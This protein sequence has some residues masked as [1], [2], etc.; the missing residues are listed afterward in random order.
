[1]TPLFD[2]A[3]VH[4]AAHRW[5]SIGRTT[6]LLFGLLVV[7]SPAAAQDAAASRPEMQRSG[8]R[9]LSG[10][11]TFGVE[12]P[13][14][15]IPADHTFRAVF[16]IV[17]GDGGGDQPHQEI[18]T[19]ARFMNVHA[20]HGVP[21]DQVQTAAV[22]HGGGFAALLHDEAYGARYDGKTNPTRELVE[23]LMANGVQV[24]LCGQTAGSRGIG[25]EDLIPGV[26]VALSAMT[27]LNYF[28]AQGFFL[29]PW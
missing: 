13:S 3:F 10:G 20:R 6:C 5:A 22:V 29:N 4:R 21:D 25:Q 1:M 19:I 24:V 12:A 28:L 8:P 14:F 9:I 16:E 11:P 15:V 7:A 2:S 17:D 26:Q 23:E 27:A 18:T